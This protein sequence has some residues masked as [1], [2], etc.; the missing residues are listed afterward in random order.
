[1]GPNSRGGARN[2]PPSQGPTRAR[3]SNWS[4]P[5]KGR[6]GGSKGGRG[7]GRGGGR[8]EESSGGGSG[9][10]RGRGNGR[11][12]GGRSQ[13][14]NL[15]SRLVSSISV[16]A[17]RVSS[18]AEQLPDGIGD[19]ASL[20]TISVPP[21]VVT[22]LLILLSGAPSLAGSTSS[23][24]MIGKT[25]STSSL[26]SLTVMGSGKN[27]ISLSLPPSNKPVLATVPTAVA[28]GNGNA[29]SALMA[30]LKPKTATTT[31]TAQSQSQSLSQPRTGM[32]SST[33]SSASSSS[34][35]AIVPA[36]STKKPSYFQLLGFTEEE[37][38]IAR[39]LMRPT[40][41]A[42]SSGSGGQKTGGGGMNEDEM[43]LV[44]LALVSHGSIDCLTGAGVAGA[45]GKHPSTTNS[46]SSSSLQQALFNQELTDEIE[47]L[48]S[49][50]GIKNVTSRLIML[51]SSSVG[52]G[53]GGGT[54]SRPQQCVGS[55]VE[56]NLTH[57]D[58]NLP[59]PI[60]PSTGSGP[61]LSAGA[62]AMTVTFVVTHAE[63]YPN[64]PSLPFG[65]A[66]R[67]VN[68]SSTPHLRVYSPN[69]TISPYLPQ[70]PYPPIPLNQ[71]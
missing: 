15:S 23:M 18:Y 64:R 56:I 16:A 3:F 8:D 51:F 25:S 62:V 63:V 53:G 31:T 11:S 41:G 65:W 60:R 40:G 1:M 47:V 61:S 4:P 29:S 42:A 10:G 68:Q 35:N 14:D 19:I 59:T 57:A 54:G 46:A 7:G 70:S 43:L 9:R 38:S 48:T 6:G 17:Q 30:A 24:A 67:S 27:P 55:I 52:G 26:S 21:D 22:Q 36:S 20:E 37:E 45:G 50:Y 58:L 28:S 13:S 44:L 34:S 66:Y 32:A 39:A 71:H 2:K 33:G 5:V 49:I 69:D 12:S